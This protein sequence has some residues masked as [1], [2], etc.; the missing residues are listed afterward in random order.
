MFICKFCGK[1]CK[2]ANSLRNH[3][4]L[5]SKNPDRQYSWF[6]LNPPSAYKHSNQFIKA[7]EEGKTF[8]VSETTRKALS[9]AIKKRDKSFTQ[10]V[11]KKISKTVKKKIK[12][13]TWHVS[14]KKSMYYEYKGIIFH[15]KWELYY[16]QYLDSKNIKWKRPS[17]TFSYIFNNKEKYYTPDF[18]IPSED[19]YI[20]IKG[21]K[22]E[23]DEAK[24][25]QFPKN[26]K[27]LMKKDLKDLGINI[28]R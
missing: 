7:K 19:L 14:I 15:G 8:E 9:D 2:N 11:G 6:Q 16:A 21:Y 20:E 24:W 17:E 23:K 13:G 5:C 12:D 10:A 26:L 18:Y 28:D 25:K 4:R 3:E 27:V 22:T 1:E